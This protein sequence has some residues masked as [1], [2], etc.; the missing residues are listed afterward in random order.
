PY[1]EWI[2]ADI[3]ADAWGYACAGWPERAAE[4]AF[5]DAFLSHRG[6]GVYGA[7]FFA[8]TIAAAFVVELPLAALRIGLTEIPQD[9]RLAG[10]VRWAM[11]I[12]PRLK[13][14]RDA[15]NAVA[16]RFDGMHLVHTNNNACLTI[17]AL[18]LGRN[19]FTKTIGP[20]VAM[21][22]D[23]DCNAATAG[24]ILGAVVGLDHIPEHWWKPF[25]NRAATY[26]S[27]VRAFRNDE[28]V[29]RFTVLNRQVWAESTR[30][31]VR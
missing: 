16:K 29:R 22:Y 27:G 30:D 13:T 19:D 21:G 28:I 23:N 1:Q 5:R 7:M 14:W 4:M 9:C 18:L 25:G 8:A 26:L 12:A 24:S 6:N 10:D 17:F 2:G 20:C 15:H 3:R 11:R 31:S